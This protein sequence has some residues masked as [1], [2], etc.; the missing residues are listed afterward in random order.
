[1]SFKGSRQGSEKVQTETVSSE[2]LEESSKHKSVVAGVQE[3]MDDKSPTKPEKGNKSNSSPPATQGIPTDSDNAEKN[4]QSKDDHQK[5]HETATNSQ[6]CELTESD[7]VK[8]GE[9]TVDEEN[10][11]LPKDSKKSPAENEKCNKSIEI[12]ERTKQQAFD[13][14]KWKNSSPTQAKEK[15]KR[16]K[17]KEVKHSRQT[18]VS[19]YFPVR[20]SGRKSKSVLENEKQKALEEALLSGKEEGLEVQE[21]EGKGRG[22]FAKIDFTRGQ[23]VCEYAGELIN[24]ETAKEREKFYEGKTEFGCYM[25][26]FN[27]KDKKYCVDATKES[28]R[29]GRLLNHS[30]TEANC[31]TR[32]VSIKDRPYL[33]LE[34]NRDV[35]VG[36]ELLYD[37]GERSKDILQFHQW[38]KS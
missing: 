20:R 35:K 17:K 18:E 10:K 12:E 3:N 33:I 21:V 5:S 38:L 6:N 13:L 9:S 19:E 15:K 2:L 14:L 4:L 32:L 23:F 22:V 8:P 16:I 27:F 7:P 31:V 34:T 28:G 26:Y 30:R 36:E 29:L 37:Y 24:Y 1:M 25:Y 11:A